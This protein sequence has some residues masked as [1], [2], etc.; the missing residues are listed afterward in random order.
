MGTAFASVLATPVAR[1]ASDSGPHTPRGAEEPMDS[2]WAEGVAALGA[3]RRH[4]DL[5]R[6]YLSAES[7]GKVA[8]LANISGIRSIRARI[9]WAS[10]WPYRWTASTPR[11]S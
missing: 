7:T 1:F 8:Y 3:N 5:R 10:R 11:C 2:P 4:L 6:D 9:R